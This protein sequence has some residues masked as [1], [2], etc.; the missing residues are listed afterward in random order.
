MFYINGNFPHVVT[1]FFQED[2][3]IRF[4]L[5]WLHSTFDSSKHWKLIPSV[6]E[7]LT[8]TTFHVKIEVV[9]MWKTEQYFLDNG[10][11]I[12]GISN[13]NRCP[14]I[15][16]NFKGRPISSY[17]QIDCGEIITMELFE[18]HYQVKFA[19]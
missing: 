12:R 4:S 3:C 8:L 5:L 11:S 1:L 14:L 9:D 16:I 15:V 10:G 7:S 17:F 2:N 19:F 18:D 6:Q 13:M